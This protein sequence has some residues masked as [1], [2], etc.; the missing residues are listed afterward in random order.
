MFN[1][2]NPHQILNIL[3]KK[4]TLL[5][6]VFSKLATVKD[7]VTQIFKELRVIASFYDQHVKRCKKLV[8]CP[9]EYFCEICLSRWAKLAWKTSLLLIWELAQIF[10]ETL[11]ADHKYPLWYIFNLQVLYQMLLSK[12]LKTFS[13]FLSPFSK[14]SSNFEHFEKKDDIQSQCICEII[15]CQRYGSRNVW[16]VS[17]QSTLWQWTCPS[18]PN[19]YQICMKPFWSYFLLTVSKIYPEEFSITD[20]LTFRTLC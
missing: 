4:I 9:S 10:I 17:F 19:T 5:A 20:I 11:N 3:K 1:L 2:C 6:Y 12:R 13:E 18:V 8:K 16:L 14:S 7:T 15:D